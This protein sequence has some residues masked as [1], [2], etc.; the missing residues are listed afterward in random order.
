MPLAVSW[1][2]GGKREEGGGQHTWDVPFLVLAGRAHVQDDR[3][4]GLAR[5]AGHVDAAA[6]QPRPREKFF[7]WQLVRKLGQHSLFLRSTVSRAVNG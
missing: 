7:D 6:Q 1:G 5:R 4:R 3:G 2:G